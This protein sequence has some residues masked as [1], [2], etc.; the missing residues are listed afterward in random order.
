MPLVRKVMKVGSVRAVS[1]PA[2]WL[3]WIERESGQP[4]KEVLLEVGDAIIV[5]PL[6]SKKEKDEG[7]NEP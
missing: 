3:R 7:Q 5:T 2:D 1:L 4:L 6:L